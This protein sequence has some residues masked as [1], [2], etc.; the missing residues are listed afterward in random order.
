M[1]FPCEQYFD[2]NFKVPDMLHKRKMDK[3]LE[4]IRTSIHDLN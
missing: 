2:E 3:F 1:F 4:V